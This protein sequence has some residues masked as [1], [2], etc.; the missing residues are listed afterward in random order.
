MTAWQSKECWSQGSKTAGDS[1][2]VGVVSSSSS[3][4]DQGAR[5]YQRWE[6][7]DL[8]VDEN[9][10]EEAVEVEDRSVS[11]IAAFAV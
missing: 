11:E 10:G 8:Q 2:P 6:D 1:W 9:V 4:A 3:T 5:C 7:I